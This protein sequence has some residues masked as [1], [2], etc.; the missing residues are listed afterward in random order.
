[1]AHLLGLGLQIHNTRYN[2]YC[3]EAYLWLGPRNLAA[4]V[5]SFHLWN[6]H[7]PFGQFPAAPPLVYSDIESAAQ[8]RGLW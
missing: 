3:Q 5:N 1:M 4:I 6:L 7:R 8:H 2:D